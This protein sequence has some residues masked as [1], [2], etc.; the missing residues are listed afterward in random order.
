[1]EQKTRRKQNPKAGG[2]VILTFVAAALFVLF[3]VVVIYLGTRLET[4]EQQ[5][6]FQPPKITAAD[7]AASPSIDITDGQTVYVPV[8]SHIYSRGGQAFLLETTLSIRNTDPNRSIQISSV[9]YFDTKGA[10]VDSFLKQPAILK[11]LETLSFLVEKQDRRGGS[12]A[13]FIVVWRAEGN[14]AYEPVI[15]AVMIGVSEGHNISFLSQGRPL[16][17]KAE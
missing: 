5:L 7:G 14:A 15:E 2:S 9:R 4:I 17:Q 10:L 16:V 13:N 11:P 8:Y 6:R 1:M 12:G 3:I